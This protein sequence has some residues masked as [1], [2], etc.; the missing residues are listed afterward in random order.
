MAISLSNNDHARRVQDQKIE[1]SIKEAARLILDLEYIS[2][3]NYSRSLDA[4]DLKIIKRCKSRLSVIFED[5]NLYN[6]ILVHEPIKTFDN[7]KI[8]DIE[9]LPDTNLQFKPRDRQSHNEN[10]SDIDKDNLRVLDCVNRLNALIEAGRG[11]YSYEAVRRHY[12]TEK[13]GVIITLS[14]P[15]NSSINQ[16]VDTLES[17]NEDVQ[18]LSIEE[19]MICQQF[20]DLYTVEYTNPFWLNDQASIDSNRIKISAFNIDQFTP[21]YFLTVIV[22]VLIERIKFISA[23]SPHSVIE[24]NEKSK[25]INESC[26]FINILI[27]K[28]LDSE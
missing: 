19:L 10:Q 8:S 25:S 11:G 23:N 27:K 24:I 22:Q 14:I 3:R 6:L 2:K 13:E 21:M 5:L 7:G 26:V 4:Y 28:E 9:K 12:A 18:N 1:N 17:L 15:D 16:V 20:S